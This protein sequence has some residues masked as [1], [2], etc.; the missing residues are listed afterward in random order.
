MPIAIEAV[1]RPRFDAWVRANGGTVRGGPA[2]QRQLI[3]DDTTSTDD[4]GGILPA[5]DQEVDAVTR[6][7][8]SEQSLNQPRVAQ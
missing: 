6:P 4:A 8:V 2:P 7:P 3:P 1:E 5:P